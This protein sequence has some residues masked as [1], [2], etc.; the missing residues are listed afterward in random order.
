MVRVTED[1][2][3]VFR[4][5]GADVREVVFPSPDQIVRD[6]VVLCCVEAAVAHEPT[7]P[8][9][10]S[11]YGPVL[12]GLLEVGRKVDGLSLTKILQ[13]RAAFSGRLAALFCDIDLLLIPAMNSAAP[14]LA[15]LAARAS[16]PD[17]RYARV[18][19]TAPFDMSGSPTLTLPGGATSQGLPVGFQ[20]AGRHL[21]EALILRAGHAFQQAT[22]W[23][24]RRPVIPAV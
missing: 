17:A 13:R 2:A 24:T 11:E 8:A 6:A 23:H 12:A 1:A 18:R 20:L 21:D 7:Y 3:A 9:R 10:A 15:F 16:D 5:L 22:Q 14:T 4:E 19:F